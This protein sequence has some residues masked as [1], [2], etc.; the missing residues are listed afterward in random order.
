[1]SSNSFAATIELRLRPSARAH[2]WVFALHML[3]LALLPLAL[4]T[5]LAMTFVAM[6]IGASWLWLRR[7]P[8]FGYGPRALS[9]LVWHADGRWTLGRADG[10]ETEAQLLASSYVHP[11]LMMLNFASKSGDKRTRIL[12]GDE[13]ESLLLDRLRARLSVARFDSA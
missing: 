12:F 3:P 5:G 6:A 7:H 10:A 9:R 13:A 11:R 2:A 4:Q 8:A 1:M